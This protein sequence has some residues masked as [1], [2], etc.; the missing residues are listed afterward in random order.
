MCH[1]RLRRY[2]ELEPG[3][4]VDPWQLEHCTLFLDDL[5]RDPCNDFER[6]GSAFFDALDCFHLFAALD[7]AE[8]LPLGATCRV[9]VDD[10]GPDATCTE[11]ADCTGE[12]RPRARAGDPCDAYAPCA[13]GFRCTDW[14][15]G[16]CVD[17]L[18]CDVTSDCHSGELPVPGG[19]CI[20]GECRDGPAPSEGEACAYWLDEGPCMPGLVC[21]RGLTPD[22]VCVRPRALGE[23]CFEAPCESALYCVAGA[24]AERPTR[25]EA[26]L[27]ECAADAPYCVGAFRWRD[28][29]VAGVCSTDPNGATCDYPTGAT[30][31][32]SR[33]TCPSGFACT[34]ADVLDGHCAP[35]VSEGGAC[36]PQARCAE[37]TR[38]VEGRCVRVVP[39]DERCSVDAVCPTAFTCRAGRCLP[40]PV[41]GQACDAELVCMEG[42]CRD[43]LCVRLP[44]GSACP[45]PDPLVGRWTPCE[46]ACTEGV[47]VD[48]AEEGGPCGV[49]Q[50]CRSPLECDLVDNVCESTCRP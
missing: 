9:R 36:G 33:D 30:I 31:L 26:C 7:P 35:R 11:I 43:G 14:H 1:P 4:A 37:W 3:D 40:W 15:G 2:D 42:L 8:T 18:S 12:C 39:P 45:E 47:C 41:L 29:A 21:W 10:C 22:D 20:D 27:T 50:P 49:R 23:S 13:A 16:V 6:G 25:G 46:S 38:C 24:C 48:W 17:R 34:G 28:P 32:Y 19:Y 5:E 44:P